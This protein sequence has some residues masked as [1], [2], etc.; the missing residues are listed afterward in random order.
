MGRFLP[1]SFLLAGMSMLKAQAF[2]MSRTDNVPMPTFTRCFVLIASSDCGLLG[3]ELVRSTESYGHCE[4]AADTFLLLSG[5]EYVTLIALELL[6]NYSPIHLYRT[7]VS[8]L[9]H[10]PSSIYSF[11]MVDSRPSIFLV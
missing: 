6:I 5:E 4:L 8:T 10:L 11:Q 9:S 3:T 1:F 7:T 2:D